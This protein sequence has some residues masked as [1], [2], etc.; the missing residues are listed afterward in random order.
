[1]RAVPQRINYSFLLF[2]SKSNN[3]QKSTRCR[4]P[5]VRFQ[6]QFIT[7]KIQIFYLTFCYISCWIFLSKVNLQPFNF[8]ISIQRFSVVLARIWVPYMP[9]SFQSDIL[10]RL[11][12]FSFA[13]FASLSIYFSYYPFA[14]FI[15]RIFW[16]FSLIF[17]IFYRC[18]PVFFSSSRS[19]S[20]I[21]A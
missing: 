19:L 15:Y 5:N 10:L 12:K 2:D 1:M 3:N 20:E 13:F 8:Q 17:I 7:F 4:W 6:N 9:L 11:G 16:L 14:L 18:S 21:K